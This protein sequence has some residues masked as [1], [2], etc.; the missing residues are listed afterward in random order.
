MRT[1]NDPVIEFLQT[2]NMLR[3]A[4]ETGLARSTL[5][6]L[7]YGY[8]KKM[9]PGTRRLIMDAMEKEKADSKN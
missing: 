9:A 1:M 5:Q 8:V 6:R 4:K 7:K 3:L 2:A